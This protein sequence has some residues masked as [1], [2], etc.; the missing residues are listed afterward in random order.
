MIITAEI[1][2]EVSGEDFGRYMLRFPV[3]NSS[4]GHEGTWFFMPEVDDEVTV[5]F[6]EGDPDQPIVIG[7]L[8]AEDA[9]KGSIPL[10]GGKMSVGCSFVLDGSRSA[11]DGGA[12]YLC[13]AIDPDTLEL[14]VLISSDTQ[15]ESRRFQTLSNVSRASHDA[16]MGSI[17]NMK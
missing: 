17:R 14:A 1:S 3:D 12:V 4:M 2:L 8:Y 10:T 16:A 13:A 15:M 7:R 11:D 6:Q 5:A 9:P